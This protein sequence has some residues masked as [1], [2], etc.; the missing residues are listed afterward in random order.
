MYVLNC[1]ITITQ[2]GTGKSLTLDFVNKIEIVKTRKALTNTA[3]ITLPRNLKI[4]N[5]NIND[6]IKRGSKVDI[7]LGYDGNLRTEFTGYVARVDAQTPF[8]IYCQDEMWLLKQ[9]S[10]TKSFGKVKL[11]ELIA[12]IYKGKIKCADVT[13]GSFVIK[14]QSTAQVLAELNKLSMQSYFF[15]DVLYVDFA[16]SLNTDLP[17]RVSY[18][19]QK[20]IVSND[21][22]YSLKEDI[23]IKVKG[24]SKYQNGKTETI[25][26]GDTDGDERTL[27]YFELSKTELEKIVS[28]ELDKLKVDG[29][30]NSFTTFGIP[31]CDT[32]YIASLTDPEYPEHNGNYLVLSVVTEFGAEGFRRKI[33]LERRL[34]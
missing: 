10:F 34:L 20:N 3:T 28:A 19:F 16:G 26:K 13:L 18:N 4:L 23:K 9:N 15:E 25:I 11:R 29:Y 31:Y 33:E 2:S 24:I 1:Q 17:N 22:V 27:H 12:Y 6:I 32:G 14:Q 30:K 8:M 7:K 21:L 5:G